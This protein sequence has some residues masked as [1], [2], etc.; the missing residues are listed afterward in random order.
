[1]RE[2]WR[3]IYKKLSLLLTAILK[4]IE[5]GYVAYNFSD[6]YWIQPRQVNRERDRCRSKE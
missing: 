6:T 3:R 1:M 5:S 4:E 2:L